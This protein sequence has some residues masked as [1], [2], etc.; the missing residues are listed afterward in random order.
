MIKNITR[1][2]RP[3]K[4]FIQRGR[5]GWADCDTWWLNSYLEKILSEALYYSA[6]HRAGSPTQI[7]PS[8]YG[9]MDCTEF[10]D[11]SCHELWTAELLKAS[12]MFKK[13]YEDN[14]ESDSYGGEKWWEK[15]KQDYD[16]AFNWLR[17]WWGDLWD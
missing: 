8:E 6:Y 17:K 16:E 2:L 11:C 10:G 1:K 12:N 15:Q 7:C 3:I 9:A 14:Y 5:R 13:L 4:W